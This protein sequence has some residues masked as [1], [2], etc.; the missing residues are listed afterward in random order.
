[1]EIRGKNM[2]KYEMLKDDTK[3]V[4]GVT[5]YRIVALKDFADVEAGDKGGYIES[6]KCLEQE[7]ACWVYN[8]AVILGKSNLDKNARV[9]GKSVVKG[10]CYLT[11]DCFIYD[12][13]TLDGSILVADFAKIYGNTVIK[14]RAI[15]CDNA[16]IEG[17]TLIEGDYGFDDALI[18]GGTV[19]INGEDNEIRGH[20]QIRD[21][22]A[23]R[24]G[25][26]INKRQDIRQMTGLL[27][28]DGS[29]TVYRTED[30]T[31]AFCRGL[32]N[33]C[34]IVEIGSLHWESLKFDGK[35]FI[36]TMAKTLR[37]FFW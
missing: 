5:V 32:E 23:I 11:G 27:D 14:G 10:T 7:G 19:N 2:K 36:E 21:N 18:I 17:G 16:H 8:E 15:I 33:H 26:R 4:N 30:G 34:L 37:T 9:Y 25:A 3:V 13:V 24:G 35:E 12:G 29:V 20:F 22:S 31:K 1:M 28:Y 6:E